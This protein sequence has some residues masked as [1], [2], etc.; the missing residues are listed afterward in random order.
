MDIEA[1]IIAIEE[2]NMRRLRNGVFDI[3]DIF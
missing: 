1:M 3:P 2:S